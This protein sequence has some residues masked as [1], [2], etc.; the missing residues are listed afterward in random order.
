[1]RP[2]STICIALVAL[3]LAACTTL[4]TAPY[5]GGSQRTNP[6]RAGD[7]VWVTTD[8]TRRQLEV[9]SAS[10]HEICSKDECI[11]A[12]R[13][14]FVEREE[15]DVLRTAGAILVVVAL[16]ALIA[17]AHSGSFGYPGFPPGT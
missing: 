14:H 1:M 5:G 3:H 12:E 2:R 15:I 17:V 9:T 4:S 10:A 7:R 16:A 13:I 6:V 11:P 8:S